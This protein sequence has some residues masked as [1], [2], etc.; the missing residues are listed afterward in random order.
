MSAAAEAKKDQYEYPD[1][2]VKTILGYASTKS[3]AL[4]AG[5]IKQLQREKSLASGGYKNYL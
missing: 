1:K 5:L 2:S 3:K 4:A